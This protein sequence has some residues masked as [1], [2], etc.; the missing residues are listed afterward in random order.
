MSM[1]LTSIPRR[2]RYSACCLIQNGSLLESTIA[3]TRGNR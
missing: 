1:C 2:A 3:F